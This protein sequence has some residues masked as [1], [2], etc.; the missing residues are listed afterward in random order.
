MSVTVSANS[1]NR[2]NGS[3]PEGA[4]Q[5]PRTTAQ[6][7]VLTLSRTL[8]GCKRTRSLTLEGAVGIKPSR[9]SKWTR[10]CGRL[11]RSAASIRR[12]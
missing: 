9:S 10:W 8:P 3:G 12:R 1:A 4:D 5:A 2:P 6:Q 7:V 11:P